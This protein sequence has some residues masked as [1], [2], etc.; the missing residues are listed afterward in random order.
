MEVRVCF[1]VFT[2]LH[3]QLDLFFPRQSEKSPVP[4]HFKNRGVMSG[5]LD[6][7]ACCR[8]CLAW[9]DEQD[10]MEYG[11]FCNDC[12]EA[13][14]PEQLALNALRVVTDHLNSENDRL[15]AEN[16]QLKTSLESGD[17]FVVD[18]YQSASVFR[19]FELCKKFLLFIAEGENWPSL[20]AFV[21]SEKFSPE[22]CHFTF[23][24]GNDH[25][26]ADLCY[27]KTRFTTNL[28]N[29]LRGF[30]DNYSDDVWYQSRHIS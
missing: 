21:E 3:F 24:P 19:D 14:I 29:S 13:N 20:R 17:V 12:A 16:A 22:C 4:S 30:H 7:D 26:K 23:S 1:Y 25:E 18:Y 8:F 2:F 27:T 5:D 11:N 10:Q 15:E 6:P 28:P 9:L